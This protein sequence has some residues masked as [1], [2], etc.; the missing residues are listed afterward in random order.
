MTVEAAERP[1]P[2]AA[3]PTPSRPRQRVDAPATDRDRQHRRSVEKLREAQAPWYFSAP[4]VLLACFRVA[5]APFN[6]LVKVAELLVA[7]VVLGIVAVIAA[8]YLGYITDA[9][10]IAAMKPIGDRLLQMVQSAGML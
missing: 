10:V 7:L 3:Q 6:L 5:F 1:Q 8:W 4:K 9:D 2:R